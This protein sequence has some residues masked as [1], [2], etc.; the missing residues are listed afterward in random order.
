MICEKCKNSGYFSALST[1]RCKYCG[2]IINSS[3]IPAETVCKECSEEY[4]VCEQCGEYMGKFTIRCN[5]CGSTNC[6]I[7]E[8]Y[9]YNYYEELEYNGSYIKCNDCGANNLYE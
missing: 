7:L 1:G 2:E 6:S 4:S 5:I 3:H 9:D 8:N